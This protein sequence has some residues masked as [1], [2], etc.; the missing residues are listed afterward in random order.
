[1][2]AQLVAS[3]AVLSST[4]LV[5]VNVYIYIYIVE[6]RN[7]IRDTTEIGDLVIGLLT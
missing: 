6:L 3:R 2:A 5:S 7:I 1:M 4:Q